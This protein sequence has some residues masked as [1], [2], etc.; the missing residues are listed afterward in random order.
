MET[1]VIILDSDDED[2]RTSAP[3]NG[4]ALASVAIVNA[5]PLDLDALGIGTARSDEGVLNNNQN[6][7]C[8]GMRQMEERSPSYIA[9][10]RIK[11]NTSVPYMQ[12]VTPITP[13]V[14]L[15][16]EKSRATLPTRDGI[17]AV[18]LLGSTPPVPRPT[19]TRI[20]TSAMPT[21][22][23]NNSPAPRNVVRHVPESRVQNYNFEVSGEKSSDNDRQLCPSLKF[24]VS[25][26]LLWLY[27]YFYGL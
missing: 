24:R 16:Y 13:P 2:S 12:T 26:L 5:K 10:N 6:I 25:R 11:S 19:Q 8:Y 18:S 14:R 21:R 17:S 4:S 27:Y 7:R 20:A 22:S 3:I 15:T 9:P 23:R 1:E